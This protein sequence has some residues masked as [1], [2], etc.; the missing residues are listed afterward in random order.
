MVK[1]KRTGEDII[2]V[3]PI[4]NAVLTTVFLAEVVGCVLVAGPAAALSSTVV[5]AGATAAVD[6]GGDAR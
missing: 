4:T 5:M 1:S 6:A 3:P 2:T